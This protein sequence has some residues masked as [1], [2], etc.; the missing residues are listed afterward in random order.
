MLRNHR[1]PRVAVTA[2]AIVISAIAGGD[3]AA[4]RSTDG[5]RTWSAA[6]TINSRT[7]SAEEGLHA[8]EAGPDGRIYAAWLDDREHGKQ[9][10]M[11]VS[12]DGGATWQGGPQ[13]VRIA[14]RDDLR[15]LPTHR[16]R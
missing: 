13:G 11:S 6:V 2:K 12:T 8:M 7:K 14:G 10:W 3:L 15:V 4:W 9:L 16:S 5:G 1:G